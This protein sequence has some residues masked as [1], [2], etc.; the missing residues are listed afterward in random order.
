MEYS[1]KDHWRDVAEYCADNIKTN[2]LRW[3]V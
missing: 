1:I 3:D 2:A